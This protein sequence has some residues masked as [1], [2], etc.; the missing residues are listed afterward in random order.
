MT[1]KSTSTQY[2]SVA[3]AIH[4]ASAL[5]VI[6]TWIAGFVVAN[7]LPAGQGAPI[8]LAHITLGLIVFALTLL[9]IVWWLVADKH[10][11]AP[12]GEPAWQTR[13]AQAVHLGLYVLLILM[14][15]S[16]IVTLILSG[17]VPT[18]LAGGPIP[19]FSEL[20]P[21]VAHGIMSKLLLVLFVGHVGAALWHQFVRHDHLLARMGV[22]RA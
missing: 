15:S 10:P 20:V 6:L 2:G 8:L 14:A 18:L 1:T 11:K 4:W 21:R 19:D 16:G 17:A 13:A 9:R 3:I 22:G 7:T 12:S 5:A